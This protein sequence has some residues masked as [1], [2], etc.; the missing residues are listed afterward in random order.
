MIRIIW[1]L[2]LGAHWDVKLC[3]YTYWPRINDMSNGKETP[4]TFD[5][6]L[7][8]KKHIRRRASFS[9]QSGFVLGRSSLAMGQSQL[10]QA[11]YSD[12]LM[13]LT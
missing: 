12:G 8:L 2:T 4:V 5:V 10:K 11:V 3:V 9:T 7:R 6:H 1:T 13:A